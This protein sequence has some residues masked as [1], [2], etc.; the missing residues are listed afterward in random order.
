LSSRIH[1]AQVAFE[2][3]EPL[4]E[5]GRRVGEWEEEPWKGKDWGRDRSLWK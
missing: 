2:A 3:S 4:K 5:D 1:A